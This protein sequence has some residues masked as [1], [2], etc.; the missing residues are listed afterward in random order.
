[1]RECFGHFLWGLLYAW[2]GRFEEAAEALRGAIDADPEV[3]G[4]Y[5]ELGMVYACL[6]RYGEMVGVLRQAAG[7]GPSA[8]RAYLGEGPQLGARRH[9]PASVEGAKETASR[10][11]MTAASLIASGWD[12][13]AAGRLEMAV[14]IDRSNGPAVMLL[15]IAYL[16]L[17]E[18]AAEAGRK[19][20][21]RGIPELA[22]ELFGD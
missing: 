12:R 5:V 10:I 11:V 13:E 18:D 20:V 3:V 8:V 9:H 15:A 2:E 16:L 7:V 22:S 21:F 19:S 1:M 14:Q 17:G 4:S 6:G